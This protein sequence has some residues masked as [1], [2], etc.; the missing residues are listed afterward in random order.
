MGSISDSITILSAVYKLEPHS[1]ISELIVEQMED[2]ISIRM[3]K[4]RRMMQYAWEVRLCH[5]Y[6]I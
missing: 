1:E 5:G 6:R 3:I 4:L 2:K